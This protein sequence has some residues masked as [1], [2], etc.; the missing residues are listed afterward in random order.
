MNEDS[1]L[2]LFLLKLANN[3]GIFKGE[4]NL[5][6]L[7]RVNFNAQVI[8][9]TDYINLLAD[10]HMKQKKQYAILSLERGLSQLYY[11]QEQKENVRL[12]LQIY[13]N[14]YYFIIKGNETVE[15]T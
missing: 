2:E 9:M 5:S 10:E 8:H 11:Q 13:N 1:L 14:Y 12:L 15:E 6:E 7:D 3:H 4:N